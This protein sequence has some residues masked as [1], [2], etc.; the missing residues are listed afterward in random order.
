MPRS[1]LN[2]PDTFPAQESLRLAQA[3]LSAV[4]PPRSSKFVGVSWHSHSNKW[5]AQLNANGRTMAIGSHRTEVEAALAFDTAFRQSLP[6][7]AFLLRSINF[8]QLA[9]YFDQ[10]T[11]HDEAVPE[12]RSSRFM[13]VFW[14]NKF[15]VF[16]ANLRSTHLGSFQSELEAARAFDI[17]SLVHGGR[18]NFNPDRYPKVQHQDASKPSATSTCEALGPSVVDESLPQCWISARGNIELEQRTLGV[19]AARARLETV[20][21]AL[22]CAGPSSQKVLW[23]EYLDA[24]HDRLRNA[25]EWRFHPDELVQLRD[26]PAGGM[27][28]FAPSVKTVLSEVGHAK[29]LAVAVLWKPDC[30]PK[31]NISDL[32]THISRLTFQLNGVARAFLQK[33]V[34]TDHWAMGSFAG[35]EAQTRMLINLVLLHIC[36]ENTLNL[37]PEEHMPHSAPVRGVADYVLRRG[38]QV[39][40]VVEAKRC[41]PAGHGREQEA[42]ASLLTGAIP[43]TLSMLAGFQPSAAASECSTGQRPW[44]L[45]TDARHWLLVD[46]PMQGPPVLQRWPGGAPAL[47]LEGPAELGLLL[48]CFNQLFSQRQSALS[49]KRAS[50]Q[51]NLPASAQMQEAEPIVNWLIGSMPAHT[52]VV[53]ALCCKSQSQPLTKQSP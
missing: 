7:R 9:D 39:V 23:R 34:S 51:T 35:N 10:R 13:G 24:L 31:L 25:S 33:E 15:Q 32:E 5:R 30:V 50:C 1:R 41:L 6:C 22:H 27:A 3:R 4:V 44:G 46:L 19:A 49:G 11:W 43:Q 8:P 28:C 29:D 40:A 17:A 12:G 16:R 14:V 21:S 52:E 53:C 37:Y 48:H 38:T 45:I 36:Q 18:T 2:L 42:W 26:W 20:I 47:T